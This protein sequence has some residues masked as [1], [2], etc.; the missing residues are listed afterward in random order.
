MKVIDPG[1]VYEL[2]WLDGIPHPRTLLEIIRQNP[3]LNPACSIIFVKRE[4][5]NYPGNIG[6]HPGTNIQEVLRALIDRTKYL[7]QQIPDPRNEMVIESLRRALWALEDRA[8]TRHG[9]FLSRRKWPYP[10][11]EEPTCLR[12]GHIECS[13]NCH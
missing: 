8:A 5:D 3:N 1:H 12:C 10:V 6:H 11:E 13:G 2:D 7:Q 9:R 4:G